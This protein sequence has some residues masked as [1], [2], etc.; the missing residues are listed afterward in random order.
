MRLG[1][2]F[3]AL[4]LILAAGL[5]LRVWGARWGFPLL[6]DGD[7]PHFVD[8]A[9]AFGAGSL[10]PHDFKYPTLWMYLLSAA[11]GAYYLVWSAFGLR[12]TVAQFG[13]LFVWQTWRF[14]LLGRLLS[15]ACSCAGLWVVARADAESRDGSPGASRPWAAALLA[16][17][18]GLAF[19]AHQAKADSLMFCLSAAAWLF[20]L[21]LLKDGREGDAAKAGLFSGLAFA[22]QYTALPAL[23]LAPLACALRAADGRESPARALRLAASSG[24]SSALG[25]F[26][27]CPYA[28]LDFPTFLASLADHVAFKASRSAAATGASWSAWINMLVFAGPWSLA[29]LALP[30]GAVRLFIKD[31]ARLA[32]LALP[33]LLWAAFLSRQHDGGNLRYLYACFPALALLA[34]QGL[35][36]AS[37]GGRAAL[38][39]AAAGALLPGIWACASAD[40][41]LTLP[42][43]RLLATAWIES[44]VPQG[45]ALIL[46]QPDDSPGARMTRE[47]AEEL[48]A[49]NEARGSLR[50]RYFELMRDSHPGGGWRVYHLKRSAGDL[51]S[52]P[53]SVEKSQSEG[54]FV[55]AGAGLSA[56]RERGISTVVTS[57]YG[58]SPQAS[59]ELARFFEELTRDGRPLAR[60]EPDGRTAVGPTLQIYRIPP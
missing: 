27:G 7:E 8:T 16:V 30:A 29:A 39:A 11:Y 19:S 41:I 5:A 25:F 2:G 36:A 44:N 60:F 26:L 33:V 54:A 22:S 32:L 59:P 53:A 58:A 43:T 51:N 31:R 9:V 3:W 45:S 50:A 52:N 14:H 35:E 34:A 10:N 37:P 55:D 6:V 1:R 12:H 47:Q 49:Q 21:R 46:D 40:R 23:A 28:I 24:A 38:A 57:S 48:R 4:A 20:S 15:A 42:D 13:G 56:L 17:S 18:P